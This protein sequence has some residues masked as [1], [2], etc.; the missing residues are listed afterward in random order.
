M[1]R[2]NDR[3]AAGKYAAI[4]RAIADRDDPFG[5]G[6]RVV[7]ALK[8]LAHIAGYR[9][10]DHEYVGVTRGRDKSQAEAFE[11]IE[12]VVERV[13]FELAAVARAGV[14][15]PNRETAAQPSACRVL[16]SRAERRQ[17]CVVSGR[18]LFREREAQK[19]FEQDFAHGGR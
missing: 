12:G 6:S 5:I 14:D 7:G 16:H 15:L 3:V 10:R 2:L 8:R 11:I 19:I 18:R 9:P 13:D 17:R 1:H 4:E